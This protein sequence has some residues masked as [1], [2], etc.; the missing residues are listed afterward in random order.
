VIS[1]DYYTREYDNFLTSN[2][3][4]SLVN[5]FNYVLDNNFEEVRKNSGCKGHCV[6]CT[7]NRI[8][9]N[10]HSEFKDEVSFIYQRLQDQLDVYKLD[11]G[12]RPE[13]I[14]QSNA[15][16]SIRIKKYA[17]NIG[18]HATHVDV[19]SKANSQRI[20]SFSINLND[21]FEGGDLSFNLTGKKVKAKKGK[22]LIFPPLWPGL[23][24]GETCL[25]NDKY[26]LGTYLI[27]K[28]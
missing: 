16:E 5:K 8:D 25:N 3:C 18:Q 28:D 15:Y 22:L 13:Q 10:F 27:Y 23:H 1:L 14:P 12:I 6:S 24:A 9:I 21:D 4:D 19:G 20:L 26:F 7:C 2:F 11:T 17:P